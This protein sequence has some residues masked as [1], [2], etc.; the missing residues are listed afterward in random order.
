MDKEL[1]IKSH[2]NGL[3]DLDLS[4]MFSMSISS[5][6]YY[7]QKFNLKVNPRKFGQISDQE[8]LKRLNLYKQGKSD[9]QIAK[10]CGLKQVSILQWRKTRNLPS[11]KSSIFKKKKYSFLDSTIEECLEYVEE[12][13]LET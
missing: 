5:V 10:E 11:N 9:Y 12:R 6:K 7:R 13:F 2:A 8:N 1:F 3:N 4:I